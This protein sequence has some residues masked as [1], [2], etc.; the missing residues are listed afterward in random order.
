MTGFSIDWLDLREPAD[1]NARDKSLALQALQWVQK[2]HPN[3]NNILVDLGSGTGSSLRALT[4]F[5]VGSFVWRLVDNDGQLLD[6]ALR[7]HGRNFIIEDYQSDLNIVNE[8]PLKGAN[9]VTASALFDLVSPEFVAA[10]AKQISTQHTALYAALNYDGK[11]EWNPVHPLD[12]VVLDA[13]NQDQ[14]RDKGF[15]PALGP[16]ATEYLKTIFQASGYEV[17]IA[18]SPWNLTGKDHLLVNALIQGI[19]NA[20]KE[21]LNE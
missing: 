3:Q 16:N 2:N 9:L 14:L 21:N 15:G 17:F 10:I 1:N 5:G 4:A 12:A 20:V 19:A 8:L 18:D 13:F 6:E 7:R 11:T